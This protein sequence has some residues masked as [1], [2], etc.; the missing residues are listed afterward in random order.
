MAVDLKQKKKRLLLLLVFLGF[1]SSLYYY[2]WWIDKIANKSKLFIIPFLLVI[3]YIIVQVYFL[4]I[5]YLHARYPKKPKGGKNFKVDVFLP[6]YNESVKLVEKT[7][8]A[9][10]EMNYPHT[11]YLIDDGNKKEYKELA[12]KYSVRYIVR[13]NNNDNKAGNINNVLRYSDGEIIA[14][15][16]IDHIP[17]KQY[18]DHV[19]NYFNDPKVGVVQVA[20]DHYNCSESYVAKACCNMNDDFFA[21]TMLGMYGMDSTVIFGS[22]SVFRRSAL[23]SIGGYQPG[24]AEDLH[25]SVKLHAAK[26]KSVYVAK[27]LARGLVPSD[28]SAYFKQQFKWAY[29]VF[30]VLF[31]H[32]PALIKS[33]TIYQCICYLTRM[34][35]YLAG[36]IIFL[37]ILL[38][39]F[40]LFSRSVNLEFTGYIIHST[41]LILLFFFIQAYIKSFYYIKEKNKGFHLSG[42]LLVLG[43]WP[44][45]TVGFLTALFK[46]KIPFIATPKEVSNKSYIKPITPQIATVLILIVGIINKAINYKDIFSLEIILFALGIIIIH[47]AIFYG[48]WEN[49]LIKVKTSKRK[50]IKIFQ[51][52]EY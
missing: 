10:V 47:Y 7:L 27:I 22:N 37:H 21:A 43:C 39:M 25:T 46:I 23:Q 26:W 51:P 14:I 52:N 32:F 33:L 42:F 24:L 45:Y 15:F 40:A 11:T 34:T 8:K 44:I 28:I 12:N 13:D 20:L 29:G 17:Q 48:T 5:I 36:P 38:T 50:N 2:Y 41:P 16:D 18:L 1:L 19:V 30:G 4:W 31:K 49:F 9:V 35:F 3:F 6:T